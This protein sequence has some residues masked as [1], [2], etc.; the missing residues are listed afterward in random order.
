[1]G[2]LG[3]QAAFVVHGHGGLDEL[4]TG[5]PNRVSYLNDG[6][7]STFELRRRRPGPAPGRQPRICAA[8]T[9]PR[10]RRM[11]RAL[12]SGEDHSP[13]RDVVLLNARPPWP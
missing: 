13:R 12:L 2:E 3:G 11:L 10:T 5:G 7:V 9:R 6:R 4:T 1:M 8:A